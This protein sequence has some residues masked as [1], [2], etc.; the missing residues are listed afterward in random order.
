MLDVQSNVALGVAQALQASLAP[1]ERARIQRVSTAN[2]EA[3]ELYLQQQLL[4]LGAPAQNQ[5]GIE[6]LQKAIA[7]D[8]DFAVANAALARRYVFRGSVY[9]R[10][11][12]LRGVEAGRNAVQIDPQLAR[13]HFALGSALYRAGE[14]DGARLSTQ[15]AIELDSSSIGALQSLSALELNAG[16]LD[17]SAYWAMRAWP[18]GPNVPFSYYTLAHS[19][20]FIDD[21]LARRWLAAA[22][23]RFKPEEIEGGEQIVSLQAVLA[24]RHGDYATAVSRVRD[25]VRARPQNVGSTLVLT[26]IATY[27]AT[28]DAEALVKRALEERPDGRG[29][30]A[31]YTPR[32]L[33]AHLHVRAGQFERAR[34]LLEAALALNRRAHDDGD[35]SIGVAYENV[36]VLAM[37]GDRQLALDAW[38]RAVELGFPEDRI[39]AYDPLIASVKDDPRFVAGLERVRRRNAEMRARVD[40]SVID[41]WIARGAP[42]AGH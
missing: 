1:E 36:A 11:D 16:R 20:M 28:A 10:V 31:G 18:L 13:G 21:S 37:L 7:L 5:K 33:R 2:A 8:P 26:E 30:W 15:R 25:A 35:R 4:S 17:Q 32:T 38:E 22:V 12:Y 42:A 39:T 27:A 41:Q 23:S 3:Y 19:L 29:V 6:V 24:L 14:I 40:L 34:P 9:G